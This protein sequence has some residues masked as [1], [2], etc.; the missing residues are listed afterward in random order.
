MSPALVASPTPWTSQDH[1]V[2]HITVAKHH[3]EEI[4]GLEAKRMHRLSFIPEEV[5][6]EREVVLQEKRER[7]GGEVELWNKVLPL[8]FA[9]SGRRFP[10]I[11]LQ[12]DLVA[13]DAATLN[14][15]YQRWYHPA[16][17]L[18]MIIGDVDTDETLAKAKLVYGS[19]PS[20]SDPAPEDPS[21]SGNPRQRL[22]TSAPTLFAAGPQTVSQPRKKRGHQSRDCLEGSLSRLGP[23]PS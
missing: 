4:M 12:E 5:D 20:K 19:V 23:P 1:T 15:W 22:K 6:I 14:K 21:A 3:L 2:Y 7:S 8:L 16:N 18:V 10:V 11:G 17:A 13:A 9:D